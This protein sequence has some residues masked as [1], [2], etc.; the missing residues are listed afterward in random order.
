MTSPVDDI[1]KG[2]ITSIWQ[3]CVNRPTASDFIIANVKFGYQFYR[4]IYAISN[5][6]STV[7]TIYIYMA[8]FQD[9]LYL[10]IK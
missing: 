4:S 9:G 5:V 6:N 8:A 10:R 1:T 3:L 2:K 7:W